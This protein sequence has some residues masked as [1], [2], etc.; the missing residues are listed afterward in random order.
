MVFLE[1]LARIAEIEFFE[2]DI[3]E[4]FRGFMKYVRSKITRGLSSSM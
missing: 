1:E 2:K 3:K 4:G